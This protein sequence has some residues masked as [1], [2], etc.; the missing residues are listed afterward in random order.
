[1]IGNPYIFGAG[2]VAAAPVTVLRDG[3]PYAVVPSG[4]VVDVP[5]QK[6]LKIVLSNITAAATTATFTV[7]ADTEGTIASFTAD[8]LTT[9]AITVDAV[10]I[11][12]PQVLSSGDVVVLTFDAAAGGESPY[13]TGTYT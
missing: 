12:Y 4:E 13:F 7:D 10:A 9:V 5:S 1:M 8:G 2:K 11:S 3:S 6:T